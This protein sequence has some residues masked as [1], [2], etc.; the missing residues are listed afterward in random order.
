MQRLADVAT[1]E[2]VLDRDRFAHERM[3]RQAG[4]QPLRHRHFAQ[5]RLGTA[6]QLHEAPEHHGIE[7]ALGRVAPRRMV[8]VGQEQAAAH[9]LR[10]AVLDGGGA[11][12]VAIDQGHGMGEAGIDRH[13]GFDHRQHRVGLAAPGRIDAQ[14]LA[15]SFIGD[16]RADDQA[17]DV[18]ARYAGIGQR[19]VEGDRGVAVGIMR[20]L[21]R[22]HPG[23][24]AD[25][26]ALADADDGRD[27]AEATHSSTPSARSA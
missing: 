13:A 15:G 20:L 7:R 11:L 19:L 10:P 24:V 1:I 14:D 25:I 5:L 8:D 3:R 9:R 21:P 16:G 27:L 4:G 18:V 26:V 6:G 17:V 12:V 22:L 23:V 2:I